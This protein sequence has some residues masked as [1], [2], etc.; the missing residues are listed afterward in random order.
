MDDEIF[1]LKIVQLYKLN[2]GRLNIFCTC[3][4]KGVTNYLSTTRASAV[5][6][7]AWRALRVD[8]VELLGA[9]DTHLL[10]RAKR[11]GKLVVAATRIEPGTRKYQKG[12]L[13]TVPSQGLTSGR[14][15]CVEFAYFYLV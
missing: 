6:V 8:V 9:L 15:R 4:S 3:R 11:N 10:Y 2:L 13:P 7:G 5:V 1:V 12:G 14:G